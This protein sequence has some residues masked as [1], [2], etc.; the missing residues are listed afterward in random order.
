MLKAL[1]FIILY[2][3][4]LNKLNA[5]SC[6]VSDESK[7]DCGYTGITQTECV[8]SGCCWVSSWVYTNSLFIIL[9]LLG[10]SWIYV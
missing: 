3:C 7:V 10:T 2:L 8:A 5:T 9:Y 1:L 4:L 6:A